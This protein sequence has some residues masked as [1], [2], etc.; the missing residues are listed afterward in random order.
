MFTARIPCS[1][2][3]HATSAAKDTL[4]YSVRPLDR[5]T[6][7]ADAIYRHFPIKGRSCSPLRHVTRAGEERLREAS[8]L[9]AEGG[10]PAEMRMSLCA[11]AATLMAHRAD[12][13][14]A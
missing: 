10:R 2:T 14:R 1:I 8:K 5:H 4:C 9:Y 11:D 3:E 7:A 13:C 12:G 6:H